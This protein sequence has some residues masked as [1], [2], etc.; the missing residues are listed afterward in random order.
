MVRSVLRSTK[1]LLA[2]NRVLSWWDPWARRV[3]RYNKMLKNL[4]VTTINK[5]VHDFPLKF[6]IFVMA[7]PVTMLK[8]SPT[9]YIRL[10]LRSYDEFRFVTVILQYS[11]FSKNDLLRICIFVNVR[12]VM[13]ISSLDIGMV[14]A[15]WC[16]RIV[17]YNIVHRNQIQRQQRKPWQNV[18]V[19]GYGGTD[20]QRHSN[21]IIE[22][23]LSA[24][25]LA[26]C[27][28]WAC[29]S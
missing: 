9:N 5:N 19:G 10:R 27:Y 29:T 20:K 6:C 3:T 24:R 21:G 17:P 14:P 15:R 28:G 7:S 1:Y 22:S 18:D 8:S 25:C 11:N 2:T 4:S 26:V 12:R 16:G 23:I 13:V